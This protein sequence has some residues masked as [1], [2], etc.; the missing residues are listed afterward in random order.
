MSRLDICPTPSTL[1]VMSTST[2]KT[3]TIQD[4]LQA[5]RAAGLARPY[6]SPFGAITRHDDGCLC[7]RC[8]DD[9][10]VIVSGVNRSGRTTT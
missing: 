4:S 8:D 10:T 9:G 2:T 1:L 6:K 7:K 5:A 3:T